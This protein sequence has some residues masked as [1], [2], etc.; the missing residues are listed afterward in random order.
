MSMTD[1]FRSLGRADAL[2]LREEAYSLSGTQIIDREH[3][4]PAFDPQKD[5]SAWPA[6]AP[7]TDEGQVWLLIQPHN[8]SNYAD[9]PSSLRALWGLAHTTDPKKAKPWVNAHGTSGV[10]MTGECYKDADGTVWRCLQDNTVY[11]A[12]TWPEGWEMAE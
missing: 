11:D 8:A 2:K 6:G 12:A 9:R 7:V 1:I 10:Y 3:S 4:V 5:Y